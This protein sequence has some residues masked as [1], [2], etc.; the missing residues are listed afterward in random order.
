MI[1]I[2]ISGLSSEV[3]FR[4]VIKTDVWKDVVDS[5]FNR[6]FFSL[7][8]NSSKNIEIIVIISQLTQNDIYIYIVWYIYWI[9]YTK[10]LKNRKLIYDDKYYVPKY[11]R[12]LWRL[13]TL[14][15]IEEKSPF[16]FSTYNRS[17]ALFYIPTQPIIH[18]GPNMVNAM[19]AFLRYWGFYR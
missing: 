9:N 3:Q 7:N 12:Q 2:N 15:Y 14:F 16:T 13:T 11:V 18:P 6:L 10:Y 8:A 1:V 4:I 5:V 19:A 17:F